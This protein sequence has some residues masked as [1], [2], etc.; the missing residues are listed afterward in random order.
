PT[1]IQIQKSSNFIDW[2]DIT[3]NPVI[4]DEDRYLNNQIYT[5]RDS[6]VRKGDVFRLYIPSFSVD[7]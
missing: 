5:L 2:L 4:I 7:A 6:S 1:P 3:V